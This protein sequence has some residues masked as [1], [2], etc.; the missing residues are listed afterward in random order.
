MELAN[1]DLN[2]RV[3]V[4]FDVLKQPLTQFHDQWDVVYVGI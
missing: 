2:F 3:R 1:C 4:L